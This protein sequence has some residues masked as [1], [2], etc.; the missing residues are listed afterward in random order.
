MPLLIII[1]CHDNQNAKKKS[2]NTFNNLLWAQ[3]LHVASL[4]LGNESLFFY[5]NGPISLVAMAT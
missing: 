2:K 1:G 5:E 4:G 3:I